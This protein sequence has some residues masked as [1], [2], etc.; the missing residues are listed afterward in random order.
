MQ[1]LIPFAALLA[2]PATQAIV[3]PDGTGRLPA[4]GWNSW[5][6]YYCDID[7][8]KI[9]TAAHAIID[10]G[11]KD[12]GYEYVN[13]DD[14]WSIKD[15]RD[16]VTNQIIPDPLKFPTG[17]KGIADEIHDLGLK[18]GIYG[19]AGTKTC[20]G[21]P[22]QIGNE[23]LDAATFAAWE[24]D[25]LKYDNCYVPD[26]WTDIYS[27]CVP[28]Q[29]QTYGPYINGTC[30]SASSGQD[31]ISAP[32]GYDWSTSLSAIR[33]GIMSDALLAQNRTILYSLCNWG[34]AAVQTWGGST[35][36]SWRIT[37]DITPWWARV[38]EILNEG[39][40]LSNY[41][42][43]WGHNDLDMLHIGNGN[44]TLAESRSHFAFWAAM[45][46]P[47]IIG[48]DL[49]KLDSEKVA[50]LKNKALLAFHQDDKFGKPA[51]PYKWGVNPN[52]TFNATHPAEYWSGASKAGTLVLA[53]NTL[54]K[55][56]WREIKFS[57]VPQL[58]KLGASKDSFEVRDIWS[59]KYLGCL[60][61]SAGGEGG[62]LKLEFK[63]R[64]GSKRGTGC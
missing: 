22:A 5:N 59:G 24:I 27:A 54:E 34:H 60:G 16:N 53:M 45:K 28:D 33:Y 46:S 39:S 14:C 29:W 13:I 11:L 56:A 36:S 61:R 3:L 37:G 63:W 50:I 64:Q 17:I 7:E 41:A 32:P 9:L 62:E 51:E 43:F 52:W 23:Y 47:I 18:V 2:L 55:K 48:T 49:L 8:A 19:S 4:L 31:E 38:A 20:G 25:Y 57:E 40:F 15:S 1:I 12:A 6:A 21:F 26:N 58:K 44:L 42:N 30:P 35:G 10:L